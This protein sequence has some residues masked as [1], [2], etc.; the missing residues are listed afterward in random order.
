MFIFAKINP[1]SGF[2]L[3]QDLPI[4]RSM[5]RQIGILP[6]KKDLYNSHNNKRQTAQKTHMPTQPQNKAS[7]PPYMT[8]LG[9]KPCVHHI[10]GFFICLKL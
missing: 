10:I 8:Q 2:S 3:R 6:L 7:R 5:P 4:H 9:R 1:K